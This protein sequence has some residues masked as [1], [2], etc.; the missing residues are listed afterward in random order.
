MVSEIECVGMYY[1]IE[2]DPVTQMRPRDAQIYDRLKEKMPVE[3]KVL[4]PPRRA[5]SRDGRIK[6]RKLI[7]Y[8]HKLVIVEGWWQA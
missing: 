2:I 4:S 5:T 6:Y 3:M 1:G 7:V 8:L